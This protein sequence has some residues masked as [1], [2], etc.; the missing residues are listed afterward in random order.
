VVLY[1]PEDPDPQRRFKMVFETH[2]RNPS[3]RRP[4]GRAEFNVAFSPDG[5][6]W[7]EHPIEPHY[8][9]C[10]MGGLIKFNGC[11]YISSQS[12]GGHF[13]HGRNLETFVSYDFTTWVESDCMG[14]NRQNIPPRPMVD[15]SHAGEQVHLG[16]GLWNRDNVIIGMYGQWHGPPTNDR[17][18]VAMDLGLVVSND[19]LHYREPIPD[20]RMVPAAENSSDRLFGCLMQGQG[21][22]NIGGETLF[23]YAPWG[24]CNGIRV[25]RWPQDRLGYFEAFLG[26]KMTS[27]QES[28][29][30]SAPIDLEGKPAQVYLNVDGLSEHAEVSAEALTE[31]F[32]VI[33]GFTADKFTGPSTSGLRQ[34]VT[35][36]N[37]ETLENIDGCVRVRVNFGGIRPEDVKIHAVYV[38][39]T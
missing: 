23:W 11:Y 22:E 26:S 14:L 17:K 19:V 13:P 4:A 2:R 10:E 33:P 15:G 38:S 30:I 5:F 25:A 20:F 28:H 16:A 1:E 39:S 36:Q 18:A 37:R 35:W 9:S 6:N 8:L 34:L 21:F 3:P 12:G 27:L 24:G 31:K 32:E 29:F 7:T